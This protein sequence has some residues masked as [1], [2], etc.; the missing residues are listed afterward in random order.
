MMNVD[1]SGQR[2]T[3]THVSWDPHWSPDSWRLAYSRLAPDTGDHDLHV[4]NADGTG[5]RSLRADRPP[6]C[7]DALERQPGGQHGFDQHVACLHGA[8]H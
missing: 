3:V 6:Q 1:G 4:V 7:G 5:E 8:V 2:A